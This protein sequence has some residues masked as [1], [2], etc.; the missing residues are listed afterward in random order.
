MRSR[1]RERARHGVSVLLRTQNSEKRTMKNNVKYVRA[2]KRNTI[3]YSKESEIEAE[4]EREREK[5]VGR[6]R[7]YNSRNRC[8]LFAMNARSVTADK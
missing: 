7:S 4:R 2:Y 6:I 8:A 3:K 5:E 1:E